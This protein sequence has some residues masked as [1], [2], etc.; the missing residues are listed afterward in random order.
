M[1]QILMGKGARTIVEVCA[2]V[3]PGEQVLIVTEP[4][5]LKIAEAVGA[6]VDAA[7]GE[8][9]MAVITPRAADSQEPPKVVAAAMKESDVFISAVYTSITHTKAVKNA[10][11]N[12][13]RGVML[14]QFD[15]QMLVDSGVKADFPAAAP[16][17][18][19]VAEILENAREII[20][21]TPHGTNLT[22]S[23]TGRKS[24]AMTCM[25]N[26][27]QFAPVPTVEANVSPLEGTA[28]GTIVANASIPYLGIGVLDEPVTAIVKDGMITSI[29]GG[30]EARILSDDLASKNDPNVYNIAEI[31]VG[32]NPEC[33][34]IGSMLEDEGVFGSVHIGIGSSLTLGGNVVAA[35]HYDL[36][37]T[38][39]TLVVDGQTVIKD[40]DVLVGK[41]LTETV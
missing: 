35:C 18:H 14:T 26:P 31:G 39:V 2:G 15:E 20:L 40:G 27:G 23:A 10:V 4:R 24:N 3:K 28:N 11:A 19:A 9:A 16:I 34:F 5:Q 30:K 29:E 13:S 37:M 36:I 25:V 12:G 6:A 32:L 8:L 1:N 22:M 21:T 33:K 41:P 7:G 17:C 38:D